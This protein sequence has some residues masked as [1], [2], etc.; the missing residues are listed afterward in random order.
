MAA[1]RGVREGPVCLR[2]AGTCTSHGPGE[3]GD[4]PGFS[5]VLGGSTAEL[6]DPDAVAGVGWFGVWGL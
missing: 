5:L 6:G 1:N 2:L 4:D 3:T